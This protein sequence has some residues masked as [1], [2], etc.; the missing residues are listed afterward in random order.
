[1]NFTV[2]QDSD[3]GKWC[4][5]KND[6]GEKLSEWDSRPEAMKE[7]KK[8]LAEEKKEPKKESPSEEDEG[9]HEYR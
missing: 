6:T 9:D 5:Y 1:M 2:Q 3:T 8:L 7:L 4:V